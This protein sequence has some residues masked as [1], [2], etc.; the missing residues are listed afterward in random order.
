MYSTILRDT[1]SEI[2][3]E[4][5]FQFEI[6]WDP[7]IITRSCYLINWEEPIEELKDQIFQ[8][9]LLKVWEDYDP[10]I[11]SQTIEFLEWDL[12]NIKFMFKWNELN[13]TKKNFEELV[14]QNL[15]LPDWLPRYLFVKEWKPKIL[16]T[17]LQ[18]TTEFIFNVNVHILWIYNKYWITAEPVVEVEESIV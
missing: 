14:L 4:T 16:S 7:D 9:F 1:I 6:T 2:I 11:S 15:Q 10:Q 13:F 17:S 3:W 5:Y 18:E 8:A 12:N